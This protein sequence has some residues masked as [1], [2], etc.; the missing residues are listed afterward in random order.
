MFKCL[1]LLSG[2]MDFFLQ[3]GLSMCHIIGIASQE[4]N[5]NTNR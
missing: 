3:K 4:D 5:T 2:Q 1:G